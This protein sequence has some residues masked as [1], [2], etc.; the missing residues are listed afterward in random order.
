MERVL[1]GYTWPEVPLVGAPMALLGFAIV[2]G[3]SHVRIYAN[4]AQ[5]RALQASRLEADLTRSQL[6]TLR[7]K[8]QPH[9]LFNALHSVAW[10][11]QERDRTDAIRMITK[12][13]GLLRTALD[14]TEEFESQL[15]DELKRVEEYIS[16]EQIRFSDR[17]TY[18]IS[19]H[20]DVD[21]ALVPTFLLQP[22]VENGIRHGIERSENGGRLRVVA[23]R[24]QDELIVRMECQLSGDRSESRHIGAGHGTEAVEERL[25]RLYGDRA[26][27]RIEAGGENRTVATVVL[28][29]HTVPVLED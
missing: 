7:Y 11:V 12:L 14:D 9:F 23:E 29:Y 3:T 4:R 19:V 16:I 26:S 18:E 5:E 1:T 20:G 13:S 17:L 22:I 2:V 8:I 21:T 6:A 25:R 10:M 27:Y 15:R 28:P 24:R